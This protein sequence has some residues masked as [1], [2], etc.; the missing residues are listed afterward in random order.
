MTTDDEA[1]A[2]AFHLEER[3]DGGEGILHIIHRPCPTCKVEVPHPTWY[4][5]LTRDK[6]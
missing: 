1:L 4:C 5:P 2:T 6:E 3:R